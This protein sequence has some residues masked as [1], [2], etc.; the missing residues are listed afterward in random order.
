MA[1]KLDTNAFIE[2]ILSAHGGLAR[3]SKVRHMEVTLTL[4]GLL[5]DLKGH[6]G[7]FTTTILIDVITPRATIQGL[8]RISPD[9]RWIYT[10]S[11]CWVERS[12][13]KILSFLDNPR[14][15]FAGMTRESKLSHLQLCYFVGYAMWN[16]L[17]FPWVLARPEFGVTELAAHEEMGEKWRVLEVTW[18]EAVPAHNR[19]QQFYFGEE[20][21]LLRRFD[22]FA[23]V[24]QSAASHYVL[25]HR[26]FG[27]VV[28]PTLRRV[29]RRNTETGMV[30]W[31]G[32]SSFLL[33]YLEVRVL[34]E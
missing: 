23:D 18:P 31:F 2:F 19:V 3:W 10:P 30:G 17:V 34:D 27:G 7:H 33:D 5:L 6:P 8:S 29:V 22:Y 28:V 32:R 20:D 25:D 9:D 21:G 14:E 26:E 13:G 1:S 11:K 12:D 4:S 24:F 16:Y 15:S